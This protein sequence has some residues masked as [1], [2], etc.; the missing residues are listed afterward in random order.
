MGSSPSLSSKSLN[1]IKD[2]KYIVAKMIAEQIYHNE[3]TVD[4]VLSCI[5]DNKDI[6]KQGDFCVNYYKL[7]ALIKNK[8][9][10]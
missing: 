3:L 1:M 4:E 9:M 7:F 2:L 8:Y 6:I 5:Q 10:S